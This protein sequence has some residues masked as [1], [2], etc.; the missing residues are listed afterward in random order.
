MLLNLTAIITGYLLGSIPFP[1]IVTK[2]RKKVDI[3]KVGG[4]N[5]GTAN[6]I[7]E[8]GI[9]EGIIVLL[10]DIAK[11]AAAI[12]I[13]R[14]LGVSQFW[15]L[16]AGFAALIGH[17]FPVFLS[18]RGGIGSA[19][20]IGIFL[21]LVPVEMGIAL[22]IMAI[23]FFI[24]RDAHK[25]ALVIATGFVFIPLLIWL[26]Q[27]STVLALYSLALIIFIAL[28]SIPNSQ[29]LQATLAR[30]R[31]RNTHEPPRRTD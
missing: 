12:L 18:F 24:T 1:Y 28:R 20:A 2:L 19:T 30:I 15:L 11:G 10:A 9:W 25:L 23:T 4:G 17:N 22:G 7:R 27:E 29:E 14:T 6:V 3:R 21:T 5:M 26:L 31:N 8:V 16:G 13:A